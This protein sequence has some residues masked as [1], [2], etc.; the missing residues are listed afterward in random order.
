MSAKSLWPSRFQRS[1]ARRF[2]STRW[3]PRGRR[4]P[5]GFVLALIAISC[6]LT[7]AACGSSTAPN[8]GVAKGGLLSKLSGARTHSGTLLL[9]ENAGRFGRL[10]LGMSLA[11]ARK[12]MPSSNYWGD[13]APGESLEYCSHPAGNRCGGPVY[14]GI[15]SSCGI[16][17]DTAGAACYAP[18]VTGPVVEIDLGAIGY[19][20]S[21]E[22]HD[23]VTLR[24][25]RLGS[26]TRQVV[27][28]YH[29]VGRSP[30]SNCNGAP[31][32]PGRTLIAFAK[33]NTIL[34]TFDKGVVYQIGIVAGRHPKLC[35]G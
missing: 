5:S 28:R 33:K 9:D 1:V 23:A 20:R 17:I 19:P 25:I 14:L 21:V 6:L 16:D 10:R 27:S 24:G 13:F 12:V 34:F 35:H 18:N 2:S 4:T 3:L 32:V 15:W 7:L 22:S 11:Q 29:I 31:V 30:T 26:P 8:R